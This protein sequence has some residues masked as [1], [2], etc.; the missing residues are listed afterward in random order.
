MLYVVNDAYN[1]NG[2]A[3]STTFLE[4]LHE[5]EGCELCVKSLRVFQLPIPRFVD[6]LG[7]KAHG[8]HLCRLVELVVVLVLSAS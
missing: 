8:A 5:F 2:M 6:A 7:D 3:P 4:V 1:I